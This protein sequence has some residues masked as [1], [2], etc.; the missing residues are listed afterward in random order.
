MSNLDIHAA[1]ARAKQL[2]AEAEA[3][4]KAKL[5]ADEAGRLDR[6]NLAIAPEVTHAAPSLTVSTMQWNP[7]QQRAIDYGFYS[8]SFCLIG[9]AGT[10]K[11]TTLKAVI[12]TMLEN[13]RIP[14]LECST[15]SLLAGA[16]GV[17]LISYTRR[18]VRNIARQM[19]ANLKVHCMTYHALMEYEPHFYEV[20]DD[21][22]Q[23]ISKTMRFEPARNKM[24]PLPENLRVIVVDEASMLSIDFWN[25]L[26]QALP[27][28]HGVQFI[29]LGDLNQLPPVYG[30]AILG[31]ML[32]ELP[33][34]ELTRVYRQAL[35]SPIIALALAVKDNNFTTFEQQ[36]K[37]GTF[38]MTYYDPKTNEPTNLFLPLNARKV[39]QKVAISKAGRGTVILQP[40]KKT[41]EKEDAC[42]AMIGQFRLWHKQGV[43][44]PDQDLILCPWNTS[45]GTDELNK[46][47]ANYLSESKQLPVYEVIAG[48]D[49]HYFAVGDRVLVDK[50]E[51]T[52]LQ[53][54]RNYRYLGKLPQKESAKMNRWG[55]GGEG[56][57]SGLLDGEMSE[58]EVDMMLEAAADV[59]DRTNEASHI[60][61]VRFLDTDEEENISK[62]A[63]INATSFAYAITVHKAQGSECRK[64]F[65]IT[66]ACHAAMCS[67]ELVYT[68]ITRAAEELHIVMAPA[69]L[70]N[71]ASKPRI[72]G[73]TLAAKLEYFQSRLQEKME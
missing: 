55:I 50:M 62:S 5:Q 23:E 73:D 25:T 43:Y 6:L 42:D 20:W 56:K 59:S 27:R 17:V 30:Q 21:A 1:I 8:K 19:P 33:I 14:P 40:W 70:G 37:D 10:G 48:Y 64:V 54:S 36:C 60:L 51:A 63:T 58:E 53:I 34:I 4:K 12:Q 2:I 18:A 26:L 7:E 61:R 16:P 22:T 39:A 13:H 38:D 28:L 9:A 65:F 66:H 57:G 41:L 15:K 52:I 44:D 29:F 32:L 47:I 3:K 35:E 68:A 71:A 45:F 46:G 49:K 24:T 67:R 72:K 11:T 31:K 69:M